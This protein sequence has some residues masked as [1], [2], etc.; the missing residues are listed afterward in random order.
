MGLVSFLFQT[1]GFDLTSHAVEYYHYEDGTG[2]QYRSIFEF[3]L[4]RYLLLSEFY[5]L[6]RMFFIPTGVVALIL[7]FVPVYFVIDKFKNSR[8]IPIIYVLFIFFAM[9]V[10]VRYSTTHLVMLYVFSIYLVRNVK[11][12]FGL[13]FHPIGILFL[14]LLY[15]IFEFKVLFLHVIRVFLIFFVIYFILYSPYLLN[16]ELGSVLHYPL[17]DLSLIFD[18]ILKKSF[19]LFIVPIGVLSYFA[20]NHILYKLVINKYYLYPLC[21]LIVITLYFYTLLYDVRSYVNSYHIDEYSILFD[22]LWLDTFREYIHL[23]FYHL[24]LLRG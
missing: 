2:R 4:P 3:D 20:F 15:F 12:I 19:L 16:Y 7:W 14:L 8:D 5:T 13:F 17:T 10:A 9:F 22:I 24:F 6:G 18:I 21:F 23:D 1:P 11:L